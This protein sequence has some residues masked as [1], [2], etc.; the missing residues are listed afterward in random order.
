MD[1]GN[2]E[3]TGGVE[4]AISKNTELKSIFSKIFLDYFLEID[5]V[6]GSE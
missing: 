4:A 6:I 1:S 2:S 3:I 5:L